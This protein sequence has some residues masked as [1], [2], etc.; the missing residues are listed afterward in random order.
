MIVLLCVFALCCAEV[1]FAADSVMDSQG[2]TWRVRLA[3]NPVPGSGK[4]VCLYQDGGTVSEYI[5]FDERRDETPHLYLTPAGAIGVV[6]SRE[7]S[8]TGRMEICTTV[9]DQETGV[10][11]YPYTILTSAQGNVDHLEPRLEVGRSGVAHQV[12]VVVKHIEGRDVSSLIYQSKQGGVW[13]NQE[14]VAGSEEAV[15]HPELYLGNSDQGYPLVLVYL[16]QPQQNVFGLSKSTS[17]D[18]SIKS[19]MRCGGDPDPWLS[20]H[21]HLLPINHR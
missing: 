14:T 16:S 19:L 9:Y 6:W 8:V 12:Y 21:K 5:T 11:A 7:N 10:W 20:M 2:R 17:Q 18:T 4:D 15:S 1:V 13:S 3:Q